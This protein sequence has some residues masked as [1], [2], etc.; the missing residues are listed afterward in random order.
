MADI[1]IY[2]DDILAIGAVHKD[3][4]VNASNIVGVDYTT[5]LGAILEEAHDSTEPGSWKP[6]VV[7]AFP[8]YR[9]DTHEKILQNHNYIESLTAQER[10][11]M[12]NF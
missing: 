6:T 2:G 7:D 1:A 9:S 8:N 10:H 5:V 12:G 4:A 11:K 3:H